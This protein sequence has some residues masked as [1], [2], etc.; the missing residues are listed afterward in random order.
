MNKKR[1]LSLEEIKKIISGVSSLMIKLG[2]TNL[3]DF[4]DDF[5]RLKTLS[6]CFIQLRPLLSIKEDNKGR[7]SV[8]VRG[9]EFKSKE[10]R[11][12]DYYDLFVKGIEC[13]DNGK[14]DITNYGRKR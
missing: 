8:E 5:D 9:W 4:I 10:T 1:E 6:D 3:N 13:V 2:Y 11:H 7:S 14:G 12:E